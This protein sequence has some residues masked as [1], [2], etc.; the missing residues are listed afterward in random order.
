MSSALS[1][2]Q[3]TSPRR[4][5]R[6]GVTHPRRP[7]RGSGLVPIALLAVV[8]LLLL[9]LL[10]PVLGPRLE[11]LAWYLNDRTPPVVAIA[12]PAE[13]VR[14]VVTA[15][16]TFGDEGPS[17]LEAVTLDS[18]PVTSTDVLVIDTAALPDG[19]HEIMAEVRDMSR[20]RNAARATALLRTENSPPALSVSLEPPLL[21]QGQTLVIRVAASK[22][23]SVTAA[24]DGA[25]LLLAV[26]SDTLHFGVY[27]AAA[28]ARLV[29]HTVVFTASDKMGNT[30]VQAA[31]FGVTATA[32]ISENIVLPPDRQGLSNSTE[33]T[34][35]LDAAF[36]ARTA[37]P[38]WLGLWRAP[39]P[40]EIT[41]PFGEAR[42]YNGGPLAS[43]HGG[44]DLATPAGEPVLAAAA[45]RVVLAEK[46]PV[47]G[48]AVVV[49]H[50]LGVTSAY[51]HMASLG[52][53]AGDSVRQGQALGTVGNTGLSTGPH[54]HWEMRVLGVPVDPW[55]WTRR[56]V[57]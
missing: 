10:G 7:R 14:G 53:K 52:V 18:R 48:N 20:Q 4:A 12:A 22:P 57:P 35:R 54:L 16:I 38:N 44:V 43:W 29:T 25:P 39:A 28:N 23:A 13:T 3:F 31:S 33:E 37:L 45:G 19:L 2:R 9:G 8:F 15:T 55:P 1:P 11:Y 51:Y 34:R 40:G 46:L 41:A 26:V 6:P 5:G 24:L 32:F 49:D 50:G 27:G 42:S 56:A 17:A 36:A 21:P 30:G 47:Q